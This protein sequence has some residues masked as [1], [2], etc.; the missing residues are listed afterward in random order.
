MEST[1]LDG[2]AP[3]ALGTIGG[4]ADPGVADDPR[5][6]R[7]F[8]RQA[9][10]PN[11]VVAL[12]AYPGVAGLPGVVRNAQRFT[13]GRGQVVGCVDARRAESRER[14][15]YDFC[16]KTKACNI[17]IIVHS[18]EHKKLIKERETL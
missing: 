16:V 4:L 9:S 13:S 2:N 3:A 18:V 6:L 12:L 10:V 15:C 17:E 5:I 14:D 11:L 7:H 8:Q 1:S